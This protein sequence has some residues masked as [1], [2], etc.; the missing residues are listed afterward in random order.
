MKHDL[1]GSLVAPGLTPDLSRI[2]NEHRKDRIRCVCGS[3]QRGV[4]VE[5]Q[6][7]TEDHQ[8]LLM[9]F[10]HAACPDVRFSK[11]VIVVPR[12]CNV[13]TAGVGLKLAFSAMPPY[14]A[15][16]LLWTRDGVVRKNQ[17]PP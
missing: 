1:N 11:T 10:A 3:P 17:G 15:G 7:P 12:Y 4:V 14:H 2:E 16:S 8:R 5:A 13:A 9:C 6:V